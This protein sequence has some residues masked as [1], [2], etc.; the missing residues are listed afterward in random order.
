[1]MKK[2]LTSYFKNTGLYHEVSLISLICSWLQSQVI[3][4]LCYYSPHTS[5]AISF[6]SFNFSHCCSSVSLFPISQDAKPHCGLRYRRSSGTYFAA[7]LILWITRSLSSSS[8]DFV[9]IRPRTTFLSG[10]TF[11]SGA[12]H[13]ISHHHI[14]GTVHLHFPLQI[15]SL[16]L[17]HTDHL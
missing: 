2:K 13:R 4:A 16:L 9:V 3:L 14:P 8:G 12:I 1:M 10:D 17:Y 7:S 5:S 11:A 15:H 6:T